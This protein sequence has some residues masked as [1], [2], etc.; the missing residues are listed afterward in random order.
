MPGHTAQTRPLLSTKPPLFPSRKQLFHWHLS[1][2]KTANLADSAHHRRAGQTAVVSRSAAEWLHWW[3]SPAGTPMH[4]CTQ[5]RIWSYD[6]EIF[7]KDGSVLF[8]CTPPVT[9]RAVE[10]LAETATGEC[11]QVVVVDRR[12]YLIQS[13][14]CMR[15]NFFVQIYLYT[16]VY[17]W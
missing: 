4:S 2:W 5:S 8:L 12:N 16:A 13:T 17:L 9:C 3:I 6:N 14:W 15:F 10:R 1:I 7:Q 11:L